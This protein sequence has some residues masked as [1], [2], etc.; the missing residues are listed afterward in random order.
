ML[1]GEQAI[2]DLVANWMA[3]TVSGD[4]NRLLSLMAEDVVFLTPGQP[5]MRGRDAF[6]SAFHTALEHWRMEPVSEIQEIRVEGGLAYCWTHLSVTMTP[7]DGG[8]ARTRSGYT[9]SVLRKENGV[10]VIARDAN[11]MV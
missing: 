7:I 2:R 5:P 10:W 8:T 1:T 6:A 9:L 4:V 3:A 11:L